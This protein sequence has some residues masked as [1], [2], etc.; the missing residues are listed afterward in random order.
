MEASSDSSTP[1]GKSQGSFARIAI[2]VVI[3]ILLLGLGGVVYDQYHERAVRQRYL[4]IGG[5]FDKKQP[6]SPET[7]RDLMGQEPYHDDGTKEI[8]RFETPRHSH[9]ITVTYLAGPKRVFMVSM[10]SQRKF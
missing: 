5:T 2:G 10:R 7:V 4:A 6:M 1:K 3:G 9:H 8:Y